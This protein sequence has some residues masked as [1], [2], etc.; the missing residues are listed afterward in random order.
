M[1]KKQ[2][3]DNDR[4]QK[5][6]IQEDNN[7]KQIRYKQEKKV[8]LEPKTM[9][10]LEIIHKKNKYGIYNIDYKTVFKEYYWDINY[11]QKCWDKFELQIHHI[12][13]NHNNNNPLNLIKLCLHCHT[14]AHKWDKVYNLMYKRLQFL[15]S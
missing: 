7:Q 10:S 1:T 2:I 6:Q 9:K 4:Q 13:K 3:K 12:D 15:L 8:L 14:E 11:C 5:K